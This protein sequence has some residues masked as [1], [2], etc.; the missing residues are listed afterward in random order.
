MEQNTENKILDKETLTIDKIPYK[1]STL[2]LDGL[3]CKWCEHNKAHPGGLFDIVFSTG[4]HFSRIVVVAVVASDIVV[5][6]C[7]SS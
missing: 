6:R 7:C 4:I 3:K 5:T 1:S 2:S